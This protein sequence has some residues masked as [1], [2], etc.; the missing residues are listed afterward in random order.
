ME[1]E[2]GKVD[3]VEKGR[4]EEERGI[5][6]CDRRLYS[7]IH[8]LLIV[9]LNMNQILYQK[10]DIKRVKHLNL[11]NILTVNQQIIPISNFF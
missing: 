7:F 2:T 10:M 8:I 6:F 11:K 4:G 5:D 9:R 3:G 1:D